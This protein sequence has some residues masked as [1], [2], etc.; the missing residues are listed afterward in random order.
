[1]SD[2][3]I[4]GD[5]VNVKGD[6]SETSAQSFVDDLKAALDPVTVHINSPGGSVFTGLAI[7]NAI[8]AR[9]N[10]TVSIDGLCASAATLISCAAAKVLMAQNALMM[11]HPPRQL[12]IGHFNREELQKFSATLEKLEASINA[13]YR[14]RV[15]DFAVEE[16][17]WLTADEAKARGFADEL[18]D[19]TELEMYLNKKRAPLLKGYTG[20]KEDKQMDTGFFDKLKATIEDALAMNELPTEQTVRQEELNRIRELQQ[21]KCELSAV[22]AVVDTAIARGDNAAQVRPYVEAIK[23]APTSAAGIADKIVAV[24]REQMQ[25]GAGGVYG[26]ETDAKKAQAEL[27]LKYANRE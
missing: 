8:R 14:L 3:Y 23:K 25:S 20:V 15:K 12:L 7:A 19:A 16:E 9:G 1:M 10:V 27:I 11:I 22:N 4:Y 18:T 2:I 17:L 24:I 13:T 26:Q 6:D 5:L 21:M